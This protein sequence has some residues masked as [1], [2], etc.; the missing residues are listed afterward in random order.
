MPLFSATDGSGASAFSVVFTPGWRRR[1]SLGAFEQRLDQPGSIGALVVL[2]GRVELEDC[3][4]SGVGAV[5]REMTS[6]N[7]TGGAELPSVACRNCPRRRTGSSL[8]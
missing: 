5:A 6:R 2:Q 3:R 1:G 8:E 4:K 7:C